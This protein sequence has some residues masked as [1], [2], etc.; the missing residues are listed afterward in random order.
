MPIGAVIRWTPIIAIAIALAQPEVPPSPAPAQPPTEPASQPQPSQTPPATPES[1]APESKPA[2]E[3]KLPAQP[4]EPPPVQP[5][6]EMPEV[7]VTLRD[8]QRYSGLLVSRDENSIVL[9]IAGIVTTLKASQVDRV[10]VF[11]PIQ[12]RYRQMRATIDDNDVDGLLRLVQW[13]RSKGLYDSALAELEHV[14]KVQPD[15][16]QALEAK[17][18]ISSQRELA[19]RAGEGKQPPPPKAGP[20]AKGAEF[21][22]LSER[23]INTIKV[24]EVDLADP[25]RIVIDRETIAQMIEQHPGDPLMPDSQEGRE[26]LYRTNPTKILDMLFK[27]QARPL[28]ERVRVLDHPR[29]MKS[30]RDKVHGAWLVNACATTRCHG[31]SEAGRFMLA[32]AKPRSDATVYTNFLILERYRTRDGKALINYDEP[33]RSLLLQTGLPR[34]RS[35]MPHPEVAGTQGNSDLFRPVFRTE[36]DAKFKD[37]VEWIKSMYRPRPEYPIQYTLPGPQGLAPADPNAPPVTR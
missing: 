31:G 13:L 11:P 3:S 6:D 19:K 5:S 27:M 2:T 34:D 35:Q 26:A 10:Q 21:P 4:A 29:S 23:D 15:N 1:K 8:G 24:Y 25:P 14:L 36:E 30:F 37:A 7:I 16:P 9:K 32:S 18:M 33:G 22:L 17:T 20:E 28:Y 12:E